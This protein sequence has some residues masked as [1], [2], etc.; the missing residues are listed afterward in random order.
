MLLFFPCPRSLAFALLLFLLFVFY[1]TSFSLGPLFTGISSPGNPRLTFCPPFLGLSLVDFFCV[2]PPS[3]SSPVPIWTLISA[4]FTFAFLPYSSS[5]TRRFSFPGEPIRPSMTF[6]Q[7]LLRFH[8]NGFLV[9]SFC[10][11]AF[12]PSV[13]V[14]LGFVLPT[15]PLFLLPALPPGHVSRVSSDTYVS[16]VFFNASLLSLIARSFTSFRPV[17]YLSGPH[18]YVR[19]LSFYGNVVPLQ[20]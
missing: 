7:S 16:L 10:L 5:L 14:A 3:S 6:C 15:F 13:L 2:R 20:S 12:F 19:L 17:S 1:S 18:S 8:R 9:T 4:V 11:G